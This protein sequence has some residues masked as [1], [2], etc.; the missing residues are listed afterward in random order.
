VAVVS[1]LVVAA[2][3]LLVAFSF[4]DV[5]Q[6]PGRPVGAATPTARAAHDALPL[7]RSADLALGRARALSATGHLKDALAALE[8]IRPGDPAHPDAERLRAEIQ[9]SLLAGLPPLGGAR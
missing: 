5:A 3:V 7:P 6:W 2:A 4:P 1:G 8:P 9:E